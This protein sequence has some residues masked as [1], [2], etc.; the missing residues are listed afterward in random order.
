MDDF[1]LL[2][3]SSRGL[4]LIGLCVFC[5]LLHLGSFFAQLGARSVVADSDVVLSSEGAA[6]AP[7]RTIPVLA[8]KR[9]RRALAPVPQ[10]HL[11]PPPSDRSSMISEHLIDAESPDPLNFREAQMEMLRRAAH[12][13]LAEVSLI[14]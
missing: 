10:V 2:L 6:T 13:T 12:G 4:S 1:K 14:H 9:Q 5:L 3:A 8:P 11:P 7:N